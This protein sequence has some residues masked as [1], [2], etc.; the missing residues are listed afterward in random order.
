MS[1][2]FH[3]AVQTSRTPTRTMYHSHKPPKHQEAIRL[4]NNTHPTLPRPA[5]NVVKHMWCKVSHQSEGLQRAAGKLLLSMTC[6]RLHCLLEFQA[7]S[8]RCR[9]HHKIQPAELQQSCSMQNVPA[10]VIRGPAGYCRPLYSLHMT[11]MR[12][13]WPGVKLFMQ[14]SSA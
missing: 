10:A 11:A 9:L 13:T 14:A 6:Q 1:L 12:L 4:M 7:R 3:R 2:I 8:P 5:S